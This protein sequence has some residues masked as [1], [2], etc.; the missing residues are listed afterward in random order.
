MFITNFIKRVLS[1]REIRLALGMGSVWAILALIL[2]LYSG[3]GLVAIYLIML[4]T[5]PINLYVLY[6]F[7]DRSLL[8]VRGDREDKE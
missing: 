6:R 3:L 8:S 4:L 7:G 2:A 1:P 5:A